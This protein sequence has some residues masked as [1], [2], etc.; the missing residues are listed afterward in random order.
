MKVSLTTAVATILIA[1]WVG[2][3]PAQQPLP[4]C[5]PEV[6]SAKAMLNARG[7]DLLSRSQ[8]VQT[9]RGQVVLAS[10]SQ[11]V[12]TP[13]NDDVQAPRDQQMPQNSAPSESASRRAQALVRE[14]EE[15]CKLGDTA[16]ASE[17]ALA[18]LEVMKQ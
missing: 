11:D 14:A 12:L 4:M 16:L 13:S 6:A 8:D 15:A 18:A 5:P 7:G 17:K 2:E 10:Y 9:L 1:G 3:S